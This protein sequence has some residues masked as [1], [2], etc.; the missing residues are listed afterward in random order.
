MHSRAQTSTTI[1]SNTSG[2]NLLSL[3][4]SPETARRSS[5]KNSCATLK[6]ECQVLRAFTLRQASK[7]RV[8]SL[9][10]QLDYVADVAAP[11]S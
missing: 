4:V 1:H 5:R 2:I 6:F 11:V 8:R 3:I 10:L 7:P 9:L